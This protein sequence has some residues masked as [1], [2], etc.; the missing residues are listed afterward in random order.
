M[1]EVFLNRGERCPQS[2]STEIV[3]CKSA[4]DQFRIPKTLR[5][6]SADPN[7]SWGAQQQALQGVGAAGPGTCTT[8]GMGGGSGCM[9]QE[10]QNFKAAKKQKQADAA[11]ED[12]AIHP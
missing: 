5:Q 8:V 11:A 2:S 10:F 4:E 6:N 1:R 9:H 7:G 12:A 3:V